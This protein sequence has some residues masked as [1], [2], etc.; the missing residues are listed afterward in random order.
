MKTKSKRK[1]WLF[2]TYQECPVCGRGTEY[3]E[4]RYTRKP[5]NASKRH[6][7]EQHYDWCDVEVYG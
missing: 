2:I 1:Y 7:F 3:R 6:K 4:R 5:K